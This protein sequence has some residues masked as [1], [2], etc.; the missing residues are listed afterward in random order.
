MWQHYT[1]MKQALLIVLRRILLTCQQVNDLNIV[2]INM[3]EL[4]CDRQSNVK[5]TLI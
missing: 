2:K 4:G 1:D 3:G 5:L